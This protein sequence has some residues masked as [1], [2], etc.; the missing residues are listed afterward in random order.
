M[1][2]FSYFQ[3]LAW[4]LTKLLAILHATSQFSL[5]FCINFQYHDNIIPL[6]FSSW[7]IT[8][9]LKRAHQITNFQLF[10]CFNES[11]PNSSWQLWN[12]K[13]KVYSNFVSLFS[14]T[15]NTSSAFFHPKPLS[16]GIKKSPSKIHFQTFE[17]LGENSPIFLCH[18]WNYKSVFL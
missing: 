6:K 2:R 18:I 1:F 12:H 8:L 10:E 16:F 7:S 5:K 15:K 3:L 9:Q 4:K 14:V 17:C 13:I 11:S